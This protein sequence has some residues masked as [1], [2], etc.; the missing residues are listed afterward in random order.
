M[1]RSRSS[2]YAIMVVLFF[3]ADGQNALAQCCEYTFTKPNG[4]LGTQCVITD[5]FT[6]RN[7]FSGTFH[8]EKACDRTIGKCFDPPPTPSPPPQNASMRIDAG[9]SLLAL[10]EV[11][12]EAVIA[13]SMESVIS[14]SETIEI[15]S[16]STAA[17][18]LIDL[19]AEISF[20]QHPEANLVGFTIES[21]G[22]T[23]ESFAICD[24]VTGVNSAV[25][26]SE[27][28]AA[29]TIDIETG[30][31][32]GIAM[33]LFTNDIT[34]S[35]A[36]ILIPNHVTGSWPPDSQIVDLQF[37][38]PAAVPMDEMPTV[39]DDILWGQVKKRCG[40]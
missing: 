30:E 23:L 6:C 22:Q 16:C 26:Y 32:S 35:D 38:G 7:R 31:I 5:L 3:Q 12:D 15:P 34:G 1:S 11:P 25:L 33:V 21:L 20:W 2:V 28:P 10:A 8:P 4:G 40:Y 39:I 13:V 19:N 14:Y 24:M 36:P 17:P 37:S 27:T 29:G 18:N 9:Q